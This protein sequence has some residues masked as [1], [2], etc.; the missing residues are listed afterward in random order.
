MCIDLHGGVHLEQIGQ[1]S[2]MVTVAVG[3]NHKIEL[4]QIDARCLHVVFK[5]LGIVARVEQDAFAT[6]VDRVARPHCWVRPSKNCACKFP[7]TQLKHC[8]RLFQG[9]AALIRKDADGE[10]CRGTPDEVKR[11][12]Q[13]SSNHPSRGGRSD[14]RA[15]P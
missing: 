1:S 15:S 11:G 8:E 5:D 2:H 13:H 12:F 3:H 10:P 14:E 6:I 7:R 9:D 4:L